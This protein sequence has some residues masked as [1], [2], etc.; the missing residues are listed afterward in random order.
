LSRNGH[1]EAA[2]EPA[3]RFHARMLEH[4][5]AYFGSRV[6]YPARPAV[7]DQ[8]EC[9]L[10]PVACEKL[11]KAAVRGDRTKFDS[12]A[13]RLGYALGSDLYDSYVGGGV[14]RR[15]MRQVFLGHIEEP[16]AARKICREI[17]RK[18]RS[19]RK[20]ARAARTNS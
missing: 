8:D 15:I 9:D 20:K 4:V 16:G 5:L 10:T 19:Y 14:S 11:V 18:V 12:L 2:L 17:A 1:G 13:Q 6:L 7:R 3:D